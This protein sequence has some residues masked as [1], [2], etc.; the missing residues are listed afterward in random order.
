MVPKPGEP[1]LFTTMQNMNINCESW[2]F[3]VG[4]APCA[5]DKESKLKLSVEAR[6]YGDVIVVHCQGRIV[7]RDEAA[8]LSRIV[9]EV[10]HHGSKL[11]LDLGGVISMDSAG[12]GELALLQTWAQERK[13]ELKCAAPSSI[14]RALLDLTNLDS[15][16]EVH[17]SVES[18][19]ESFRTQ[20]T[21]ECAA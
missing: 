13:A 8:A 7:Y 2:G 12:I 5:P 18:A 16:L 10:L 11:V 14:V 3:P 17:A 15:V 19:V 20:L 21:G 1:R 4:L 6:N 9:G